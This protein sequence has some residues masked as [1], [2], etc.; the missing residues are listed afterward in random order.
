MEDKLKLWH[1]Y[2]IRVKTA[3][4][5]RHEKYFE[6]LSK[7]TREFSDVESMKEDTRVVNKFLE[8]A[9]Y[10]SD[11]V[12]VYGYMNEKRI[13][14]SLYFVFSSM[15]RIFEEQHRFYQALAVYEEG[16]KTVNEKNEQLVL[17]LE[18]F[19]GRMRRRIVKNGEF[20]TSGK[21]KFSESAGDKR[22][23]T[24]NAR[25]NCTPEMRIAQVYD[26]CYLL[27]GGC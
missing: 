26:F 20:E 19:E 15:A 11:P 18:K 23:G 1:T 4:G 3:L 10:S 16:L 7:F 9:L 24:K 21:R 25:E 6:L 27:L 22:I 8:F 2:L 12:S 17:D 13:G 5:P 14:K